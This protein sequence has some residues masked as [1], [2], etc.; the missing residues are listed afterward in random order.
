MNE[1][2]CLQVIG[3]E[4]GVYIDKLTSRELTKTKRLVCLTDI[5]GTTKTSST[6]KVCIST[7]RVV[8]PKEKF[9]RFVLCIKDLYINQPFEVYTFF[10]KGLYFF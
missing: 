5:T 6:I 10:G 9:I 3:E 1:K 4:G 8:Q 7:C 2:L